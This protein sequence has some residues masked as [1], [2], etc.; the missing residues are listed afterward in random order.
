MEIDSREQY[1]TT[2]ISNSNIIVINNF[3]DDE[4]SDEIIARFENNL[5]LHQPKSDMNSQYTELN[6]SKNLNQ[7]EEYTN[8]ITDRFK[9]AIGFY[10]QQLNVRAQ[11]WPTDYGY[12]EFKMIKFAADEGYM[13]S[14]VA[15]SDLPSSKRFLSCNWFLNEPTEGGNF[16]MYINDTLINIKPQKGRCVLFPS[17]WTHPYA[18]KTPTTNQYMIGSYLHYV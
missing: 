13:G 4:F 14:R 10:A 11:Q 5:E 8:F 6:I 12:E 1:E 18:V 16:E 2:V 15:A 3:V 17:V 7:F 9:E